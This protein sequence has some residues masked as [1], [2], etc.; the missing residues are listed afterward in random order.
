M[1]KVQY[2]TP[3]WLEETARI[4]SSRPEYKE[5]FKKLSA[6]MCY[7]VKAEPEWG[8]DKDII[9]GSF[10]DQGELTKLAFLAEEDARKE[11]DYILAATPQE[12]KR[13]LRKEGKF[14]GDFLLGKI[15][16]EL[17]SKVGVLGIAPHSGNLVDWLTQV[18]L[19]FPD[20]MSAEE[21]A[22][23]RQKLAAFRR[24]TGV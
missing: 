9:F 21:R 7:R 23:Y 1:A 14:V 13:I 17:G 18:D 2:C 6:K 19:Q 15:K 11:S 4:Y 16:L 24:Q 20:E 22:Q 8:I 10:F 3:E 5:K 12:W